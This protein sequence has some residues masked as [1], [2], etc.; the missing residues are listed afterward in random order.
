MRPMVTQD[1]DFCDPQSTRDSS[2]TYLNHPSPVLPIFFV[3]IN[4]GFYSYPFFPLLNVQITFMQDL[5]DEN[6]TRSKKMSFTR[7]LRR[8]LVKDIQE[9]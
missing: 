4:F 2:Q 6:F 9:N 1:F 5:F 3:Q 7:F 8:I